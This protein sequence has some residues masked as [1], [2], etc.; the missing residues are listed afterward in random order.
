[1]LPLQLPEP[2]IAPG[3]DTQKKEENVAGEVSELESD[4]VDADGH[5]LPDSQRGCANANCAKEPPTITG[6]RPRRELGAGKRRAEARASGAIR[7]VE[8]QEGLEKP[9]R[10][11][12]KSPVVPEPDEGGPESLALC[13]R[14]HSHC[15]RPENQ[16][17]GQEGQPEA[18]KAVA[19]KAGVALALQ[20]ARRE[21]ASQKKKDA[22]EIS[23]IG[24]TKKR[25]N[26][27]GGCGRGTQLV[28]KPTAGSSVGDRRV[29]Q[30]DQSDHHTA[31]AVDVEVSLTQLHIFWPGRC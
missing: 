22:H 6:D 4:H 2:V 26:H 20:R 7:K 3:G 11:V 21:I 14:D 8:Y 10:P 5:N 31:Q 19:Q 12:D 17:E 13:S 1:M 18:Q 23:L 27:T 30:H 15:E 28:I 24:R 29:V 16:A 9:E 25:E